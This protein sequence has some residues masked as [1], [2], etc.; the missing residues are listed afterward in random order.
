MVKLSHGFISS[1]WP[2]YEI[3]VIYLFIEKI[4][5]WFSFCSWRWSEKNFQDENFQNYGIY[6]SMNHYR[7]FAVRN[8]LRSIFI[9]CYEYK[10]LALKIYKLW[11]LTPHTC[12]F[13]LKTTQLVQSCSQFNQNHR[14]MNHR[15]INVCS[16]LA[17]RKAQQK[18]KGSIVTSNIM[19]CSH[20]LHDAC[21]EKA[22]NMIWETTTRTWGWKPRRIV[23]NFQHHQRWW[24]G[25]VQVNYIHTL[26]NE[27]LWIIHHEC[28]SARVTM[29]CIVHT[30]M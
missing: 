28:V 9:H 26:K 14:T 4:F 3:N 19:N 30:W 2:L 12:F 27:F 21:H 8:N 22:V 16:S 11:Q 23:P 1:L 10:N 29:I 18:R 15:N 5:P 13:C 24:V 17:G 7:W 6:K 20:P 25:A